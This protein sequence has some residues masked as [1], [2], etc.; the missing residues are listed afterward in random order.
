[1]SGRLR[2]V[3]G[4][5]ASALNKPFA[6]LQAAVDF[7]FTIL[8]AFA[9]RCAYLHPFH[10]PVVASAP[11]AVA[12]L[13]PAFRTSCVGRILLAVSATCTRKLRAQQVVQSWLVLLAS[14]F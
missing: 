11:N 5:G 14:E 13:G 3:P 12:L 7:I 2:D 6:S 10:L 8:W 9:E 4:R 1:M